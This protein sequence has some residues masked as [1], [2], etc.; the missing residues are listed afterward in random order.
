MSPVE[1]VIQLIEELKANLLHDG[2]VEQ[3]MYDK[4]A[5]WCE[6]TAGRK[7]AKIVDLAKI[8]FGLTQSTL[9]LKSKAAV[10]SKDLSDEAGLSLPSWEAQKQST[11]VRQK[12]NGAWMAG[13]AELE[14]AINALE[15]AIKVLGGAGTKTG[16]LQAGSVAA[17][18]KHA[19]STVL[20]TL[21]A[22]AGAS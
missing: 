11:A 9:E 5:C 7:A 1:K 19:L 6:M 4:Y 3:Q 16:L 13:K 12:E 17:A 20:L 8:T 21:P 22:R 14:E 18:R 10:L 2:K 15:R